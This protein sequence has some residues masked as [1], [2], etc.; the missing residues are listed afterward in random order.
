MTA[1]W[2]ETLHHVAIPLSASC[3]RLKISV[4]V[5][6]LN[7]G[8][9]YRTPSGALDQP[10]FALCHIWMSQHRC[11]PSA[12]SQ[13]DDSARTTTSAGVK[14][15]RTERTGSLR[16]V[17]ASFSFSPETGY[18]STSSRCSQPLQQ[19]I[20]WL[21]RRQDFNKRKSRNCCPRKTCSGKV[22][23]MRIRTCRDTKD[24]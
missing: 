16:A 10:L 17:Q 14:C 19:N 7:V 23:Y 3:C 2:M 13:S 5:T 9:S 18:Q 20:W 4:L 6:V 1:N 21:C 11:F 12:S 15:P 24:L 22:G 8:R